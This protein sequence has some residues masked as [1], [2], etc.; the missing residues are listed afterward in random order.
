MLAKE[1][2]V[3]TRLPPLTLLSVVELDSGLGGM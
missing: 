3:G 1:V 2:G